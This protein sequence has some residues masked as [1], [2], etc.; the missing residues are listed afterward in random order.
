MIY[1]N[2]YILQ[3]IKKIDNNDKTTPATILPA[4]DPPSISSE[5]KLRY[6]ALLSSIGEGLIVTDK[7]G[8]II[9]FNKSAELLLGWSAQEAIG[10]S[11]GEIV[12]IEFNEKANNGSFLTDNPTS[13]YFIRKNNSK[14]PAAITDTSYIQGTKILGTITLFRDITTEQNIEQMKN[15]FI[16]LASHQ[17]RT[18]LS[19]IKWYSQM[20]MSGDAGQLQ[21]TQI[22]FLN[23]INTATVRMINLVN[24]LLNISRIQ[25]GKLKI[26]P[27]PTDIKKL[28]I[29]IIEEVKIRYADKKQKFTSDIQESIPF[30][31]TDPQLIRQVYTNLLTNAAKYTPEKGEIRIKLYIKDNLL[32]SEISDNGLGIPESEKNKVF[33]KFYRGA[34]ISTRVTEGTGL[35]LYLIKSIIDMCNGK[36]SFDSKEGTGTT[37]YFSLP[38]NGIAAK[39]GTVSLS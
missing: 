34:N 18:P 21:P 37:F 35:G 25:S 28:V 22:E 9:S 19:V 2:I 27:K 15:D 13:T 26:E 5:D 7:N 3:T 29:E 36:I 16:S 11:F 33:D 32:S 30:I 8:L 14:F 23:N 6:E 10:K 38:L 39:K 4:A 24:S 20:L 1:L 12:K 31:N 17:L